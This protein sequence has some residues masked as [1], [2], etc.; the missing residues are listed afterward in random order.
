MKVKCCMKKS[1]YNTQHPLD[2]PTWTTTE[3]SWIQAIHQTMN[4]LQTQYMLYVQ[5]D[6][7][8]PDLLICNKKSL[9]L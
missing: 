1:F 3:H 2:Y 4:L 7:L 5:N 6:P 8:S 9:T